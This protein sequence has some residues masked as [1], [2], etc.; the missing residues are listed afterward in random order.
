[1][2]ACV[3]IANV[4]FTGSRLLPRTSRA[5]VIN[6]LSPKFQ[7]ITELAAGFGRSLLRW[8]GARLVWIYLQLGN[9]KTGSSD[10]L[11]DGLFVNHPHE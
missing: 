10:R 4:Q 6:R 9:K 1:M 3:K 8:P 7:S 5:D 2:Y 11:S